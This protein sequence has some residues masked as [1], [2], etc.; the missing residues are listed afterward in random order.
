M[1]LIGKK[2]SEVELRHLGKD[3]SVLYVHEGSVS[4]D[5]R[6]TPDQVDD[7]LV[8]AKDASDK[9]EAYGLAQQ[10]DQGAERLWRQ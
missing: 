2:G 5:I 10:Q 9:N 6:L 1:A 7:L 3:H 8:E 4:V